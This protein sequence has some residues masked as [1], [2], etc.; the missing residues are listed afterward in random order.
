M[1]A[2]GVAGGR[3][4]AVGRCPRADVAFVALALRSRVGGV[5]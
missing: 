4:A 2:V 3:M 5:L 1:R